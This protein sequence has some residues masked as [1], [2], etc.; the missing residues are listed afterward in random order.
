M[1]YVDEIFEANPLA[2]GGNPMARQAA[3]H[4]TRWCHM[5]CWPAT[6][7]EVERLHAMAEAIGLRRA[8]FQR[9]EATGR[10]PA[11]YHYDLVPGKR[12]LAIAQGAAVKDLREW[13][14][15]VWGGEGSVGNTEKR[16]RQGDLF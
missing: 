7:E 16:E 5:W 15:E 10:T 11:F 14:R 1:I 13:L 12:K 8:Y 6:A 9:R 4:G 3:R 2:N